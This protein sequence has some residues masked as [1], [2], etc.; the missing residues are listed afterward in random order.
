VPNAV[1]QEKEIYD[2]RIRIGSPEYFSGGA[3]A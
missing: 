3:L 1:R 2:V